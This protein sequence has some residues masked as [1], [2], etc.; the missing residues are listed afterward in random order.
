M[1]VP[2]AN[3]RICLCYGPDDEDGYGICYN[4]REQEIVISVSSWHS[5]PDTDSLSMSHCLRDSLL[6]MRDLLVTTSHA[7][8]H[9]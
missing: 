1:Q 4:P 6:E 3:H 9:Y 2:V 7:R 5:C 8:A